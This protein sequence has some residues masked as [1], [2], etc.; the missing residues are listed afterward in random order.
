MREWCGLTGAQERRAELEP[1][2]ETILAKAR[3]LDRITNFRVEEGLDSDQFLTT[4]LH[5]AYGQ[6]LD[7]CKL[8][9]MNK[10]A[11]KTG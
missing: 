2:F 11:R 3:H 10:E 4:E 9:E 1:C 7:G 8:R 5:T 6:S